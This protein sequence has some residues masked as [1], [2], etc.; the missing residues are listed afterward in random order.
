M[1]VPGV[2]DLYRNPAGRDRVMRH[3]CLFSCRNEEGELLERPDQ[4][5]VME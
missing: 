1:N 3:H 4:G 2:M 5:G